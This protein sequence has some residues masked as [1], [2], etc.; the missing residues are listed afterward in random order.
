MAL[1]DLNTGLLVLLHD[2]AVV[3]GIKLRREYG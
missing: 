1:N 3:F 2:R